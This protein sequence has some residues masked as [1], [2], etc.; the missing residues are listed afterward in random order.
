LTH[1]LAEIATITYRSGPE[2]E[3]RFARRRRVVFPPNSFS[4]PSSAPADP[5]LAGTPPVLCPDFLIETYLDHQGEQFCLKFDP[6]SLLYI[7]KAMDLFDM[8][9]DALDEI[10]VMREGGAPAGEALC[11]PNTPRPIDE[12]IAKPHISTL[13]SSHAYLPQLAAGLKHLA[14]HPTLVLGVQSDLLFPVDQQRELAE[15][16]RMNGNKQVSCASC[17]F[18]DRFPCPHIAR[19]L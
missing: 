14:R 7:S 5:G 13:P 17:P 9:Q 16:L 2:W 11:P 18:S 19:R 3:Q 1:S 12:A 15:A 10:A 6:N 8:S 4:S